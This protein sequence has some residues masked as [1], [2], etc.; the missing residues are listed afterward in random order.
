MIIAGIAATILTQLLKQKT[1]DARTAQAVALLVSV[2]L[3]AAAVIVSGVTGVMPASL[4]EF[5]STAVIIIAAVASC[6]RAAYSL[7]GR[8]IPDGREDDTDE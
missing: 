7:L 1:M 6:S 8:V 5:V 2:V 3:G 4:V